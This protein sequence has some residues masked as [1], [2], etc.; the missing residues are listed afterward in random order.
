MTVLRYGHLQSALVV[1]D[2][3]L[4]TEW[5]TPTLRAS[6][7]ELHAPLGTPRRWLIASPATRKRV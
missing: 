1:V 6:L 5:E 2:A 4:R 3:G 7:C